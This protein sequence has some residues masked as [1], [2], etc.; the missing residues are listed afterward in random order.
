[1]CSEFKPSQ[2]ILQ[3][4][5]NCGVV[6]FECEINVVFLPALCP[7][8]ACQQS[9]TQLHSALSVLQL[10]CVCPNTKATQSCLCLC[11]YHCVFFPPARQCASGEDL[12]HQLLQ[13]IST[14]LPL[15]GGALQLPET[16][17][18]HSCCLTSSQRWSVARSVKFHWLSPTRQR[19]P[20]VPRE[21]VRKIR[22]IM[23]CIRGRASPSP[24]F[25]P[26]VSLNRF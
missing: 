18:G 21:P 23:F 14:R 17:D 7:E 13:R 12:S 25:D 4:Q 19:D 15:L 6:D 10:N 16:F 24:T 11:L 2:H 20:P 3:L 5:A 26:V 22:I 9:R 8:F 1:M